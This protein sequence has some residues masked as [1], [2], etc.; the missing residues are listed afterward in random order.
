MGK[1][2]LLKMMAG[3]E[4]RSNGEVRRTPGYSV[5]ILPQEPALDEDKT[6]LGNVEDGVAETKVLIERYNEVA[7]KMAAD[8]SDGLLEEIGPAA[9]AARPSGRVGPG[10]PDRAGD[11]RAAVP[12]ARCGGE[13]AVRR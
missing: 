2:T 8:Y 11:G 5:G 9:G 3:I 6:V 12:A 4:Q 1:P 7:A 13:R 10:Q